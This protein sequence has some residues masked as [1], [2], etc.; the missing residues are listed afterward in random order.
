[1]RQR[2]SI[3]RTLICNPEVV[4]MDEPFGALDAQTRV[5]LQQLLIDIWAEQRPTICFVTHDLDESIVLGHRVVMLGAR[6]GT[7][8]AICPVDIPHPREVVEVKSSERFQQ[9]YRD[10]WADLGK[11]IPTH[12]LKS[13]VRGKTSV[14]RN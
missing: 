4:L 5:A 3:I 11:R 9:L 8:R 12:L 1:M 7:V 6:P 13:R 14:D 2:A 10:L